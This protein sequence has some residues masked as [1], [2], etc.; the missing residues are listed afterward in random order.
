[1]YRP[2]FIPALLF[3][4]AILFAQEEKKIEIL[5]SEYME[6]DATVASGVVKYVGEVAFQQQ[7]LLLRCDSAWYFARDNNVDAYGH[8][9][10]IQGDTLNLYGDELRYFGNKKFAEMRYNV[11]L[12]DKETTLTTDYLDFDLE[13]NIGY[14]ERHGHIVNGDN[15]LDSRA[16]Y[17]Y[18]HNKTLNFRDSVVIVNPDY[19]IYADTL[20]Y[21]TV[22]E[23]AYFLGPTRIISPENS[24]YCENGWYDTKHN[25]SQFN[26]NAYLESSG[27]YL[28]GDSLYYERDNGM[29]MAFDN[30]ELYDSAEQ[31]I[32]LGRYAIYFEEPEYAMLTDSAVLI[33]ISDEDSLFVHADTLKS[34]LDS[35]GNYKILRAY[36]R[37]KFHSQDMQGKCDSLAYLESDS[38]FMLFGEPVLWSEIHQLTA[39]HMDVHMALDE[40][41]YID[42]N[43]AAFIASQD[44]SLRFNQIRGRN[45]VGHFTQNQLSIVDVK[46]NGQTIWFGRDE[47]TLIGVNKASSSDIKIYLSEGDVDRVNMISSPTAILYPPEDLP[48]EELYLSGFR[49]LEEHRPRSKEDIFH[50]IEY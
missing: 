6:Y 40:P 23:I 26:K 36:Y 43:N 14:Y 24:I 35:T 5:N 41:D 37:V 44:D 45:M 17:Y 16:G 19:T 27:Q 38:V 30:V 2:V 29:G 46:G 21:H 4:G 32:L 47:G 3:A 11:I 10:I 48:V 7:N 15:T 8:V 50:W 31:V 18:S 34:V 9:H 42:L 20:A 12:V 33:Q 22:T 13:Q 1:M 49:W 25:I 28:R 39:D